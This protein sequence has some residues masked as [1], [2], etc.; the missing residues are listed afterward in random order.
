MTIGGNRPVL[1]HLASGIG[2]VVLATPLLVALNE[3]GFVVDLLLDADYSQTGDL[4]RDWSAVHAVL[5]HKAHVKNGYSLL[6]PAVPPFYWKRFE[7][8]YARDGRVAPR[9]PDKLFYMDEQEYYLAFARALGYPAEQKPMYRLPIC[10]SETAGVTGR[11]LVMAPGCKT[12]EMALKRW[13]YFAEL[14]EAFEDVAVVGTADDAHRADGTVFEFPAHV[15]LLL[16]KLT[17]RETAEVMASAG[18][19]VGNDSGLCHV[20]GASGSP[21]VIIFGPTPSLTLGK[22]PPNVVIVRAGLDC[23]PCWFGERFRACDKKIDCLRAVRVEDVAHLLRE[24]MGLK[25]GDERRS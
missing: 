18:A 16:G 11:T 9:P 3:M 6:V 15:R 17:L 24:L 10:A 8:L 22:F 13:P 2:N 21:T 19:V 12:G 20:A 7:R 25:L 1:V 14:A 23:E 4:F 5:G